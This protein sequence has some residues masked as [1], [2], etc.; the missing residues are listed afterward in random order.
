MC[1]L[2]C[3]TGGVLL[4][5]WS[6]GDAGCAGRLRTNHP[7]G[8]RLG[9]SAPQHCPHNHQRKGKDSKIIFLRVALSRA[10]YIT[11]CDSLGPNP[12][13]RGGRP[14]TLMSS[15]WR[16]AGQLHQRDAQCTG[17]TRGAPAAGGG[18]HEPGG[19]GRRRAGVRAP[20]ADA[21]QETAR[22]CGSSHCCSL[23]GSSLV[24]PLR[25][26]SAGC[27]RASG[28]IVEIGTEH[29]MDSVR[30][31]GCGRRQGAG[32][33]Q[34][35]GAA[36][37]GRVCARGGGGGPAADGPLGRATV[38]C[39]PRPP[40][41]LLLLHRPHHQGTLLLSRDP[42]TS[43]SV[44]NHTRVKLTFSWRP[45]ELQPRES[46]HVRSGEAIHPVAPQMRVGKRC[47]NE[48]VCGCR[49][50]TWRRASA[51]GR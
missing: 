34:H 10:F 49:C 27:M 23:Y 38:P 13:R 28:G 32:K 47:N 11:S 42:F 22:Q 50:G 26:A 19:R 29:K 15:Y 45:D 5:V 1:V 8:W 44:C 14:G 30:G 24:A 21:A 41:P 12:R 33:R 39:P 48:I 20:L 7:P 40:S 2:V 51:C 37:A 46:S 35:A 36:E 9:G 6:C 25:C 43:S 17:A 3:M 31:C 4:E 18:C 16:C